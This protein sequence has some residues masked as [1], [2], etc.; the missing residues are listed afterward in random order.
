MNDP[1]KQKLITVVGPT[2][3]GK[4][5]LGVFLARALDGEIIS[6]DSMQVYKG[7]DIGSA[8]PTP[9]EMQGVIHH[10]IDFLEH[11]EKFSVARFTELAKEKILEISQRNRLP[12]VVGGTGLYI[13]SLVNNIVF[14]DIPPDNTFREELNKRAEESGAC[15]LLDELSAV[16]P[17]TAEKLK[18]GNITR[19]IRALEVYHGTGI[20]MSEH[21]RRSRLLPSPYELIVVGIGFRDRQRLYDRINKRVDQMLEKGLAD[22][23]REFIERSKTDSTAAQ[24]IGYKELAPFFSGL[25]SFDECV[26][27]LKRETRRYAK[28]QQTWFKRDERIKWF[29]ADDYTDFDMLCDDTLNYVKEKLDTE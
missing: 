23:A 16:D 12:L 29:Y 17:Q 8:K 2:A 13:D 20:P 7:M 11:D 26:E 22:E 3:S 19:I 6:S 28:R 1:K 15:E 18:D 14:P 27:N 5:Y 9:E 24:A 25:L 21:E 10:L 4:T